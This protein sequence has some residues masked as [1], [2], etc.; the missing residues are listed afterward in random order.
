LASEINHV[1]A[2][3][4]TGKRKD[5]NLAKA[6]TQK[7]MDWSQNP[8]RKRRNKAHKLAAEKHFD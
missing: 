2:R 8:K 1:L 4:I 6:N 3:Q 5:P 7:A